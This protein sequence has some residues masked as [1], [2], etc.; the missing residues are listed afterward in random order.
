M[1]RRQ[2]TGSDKSTI[3]EAV[4]IAEEVTSDF[5]KLSSSQWR[6]SRYDILTLESLWDEEIS[7]HALAQLAKYTCCLPG[8]ELKSAQF[9]LYRICLQ[10]H[11][12][13]KTLEKETTLLLLPLMI[14]VITHEL[15]HIV[16]FSYFHHLFEA[17]AEERKLEEK[18][19]HSLTQEILVP[20]R[21]PKIRDITLYYNSC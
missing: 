5:F 17:T 11:N 20:L 9:D 12:I 3:Q 4:L 14:Y 16:R 6:R 1:A 13:L 7:T 2:F 10:D 19:V 15:V 18:R 8:R 21:S